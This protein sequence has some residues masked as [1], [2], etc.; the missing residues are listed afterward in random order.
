MNRMIVR[1]LPC[2]L[3]VCAAQVAATPTCHRKPGATTESTPSGVRHFPLAGPC[4]VLAL[5]PPAPRP[6]VG[7]MI[8]VAA[9]GWNSNP[10]AVRDFHNRHAQRFAND[11]LF[12]YTIEH[13]PG[14]GTALGPHSGHT[15]MGNVIQHYDELRT[16][17]NSLPDAASYPICAFGESSGGNSALNLAVARPSLNCVIA[18]GAPTDLRTVSASMPA[19]VRQLAIDAYGESNLSTFS[20]LYWAQTSIAL[21]QK[22]LLGH[23]YGD[24]LVGREQSLSLCRARTSASCYLLDTLN[25]SVDFTHVRVTHAAA[26]TFL[27]LQAAFAP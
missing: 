24:P 21:R 3:L 14:T 11:G 18:Q 15:G 1:L 20:P 19:V 4:H 8:I 27:Q 16:F 17:V 23:G 22:V 6:V 5:A 7:F 9:G 26:Q 25:G 10:Q 2:L 12:T 13:T